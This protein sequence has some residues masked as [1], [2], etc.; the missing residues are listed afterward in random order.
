VGEQGK[1]I[2]ETRYILTAHMRRKT[3]AYQRID[4]QF[5]I[6]LTSVLRAITTTD[7]NLR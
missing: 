5:R 4:P 1:H 2:A 3:A 6:V 7:V